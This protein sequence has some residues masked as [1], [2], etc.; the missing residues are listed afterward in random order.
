M[1]TLIFGLARL[2]NSWRCFLTLMTS[3]PHTH[4][5]MSHVT[6]TVFR[7]FDRLQFP[8][9]PKGH[10]RSVWGEQ[11][12]PEDSS[13]GAVQP[14]PQQRQGSGPTQIGSDER[15]PQESGL[16]RDT[17]TS[18]NTGP[19]HKCKK[20]A[21]PYTWD[22]WSASVVTPAVSGTRRHTRGLKENYIAAFLWCYD[23]CECVCVCMSVCKH[24]IT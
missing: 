4:A 7:R 22:N 2:V 1:S 17:R 12:H 6:S 13:S 23:F 18:K 16:T 24:S 8:L 3:V 5:H 20:H 14:T 9:L 21:L 19:L 10:S 11:R 15:Y